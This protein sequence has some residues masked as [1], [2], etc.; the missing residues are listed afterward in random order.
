[1]ARYL[2]RN[3]VRHLVDENVGGRAPLL[4]IRQQKRESNLGSQSTISDVKL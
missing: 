1:M 3:D 2:V 4:Q